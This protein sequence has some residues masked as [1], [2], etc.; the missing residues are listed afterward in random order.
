M[1]QRQAQLEITMTRR[2]M[3]VSVGLLG[4]LSLFNLIALVLSFS[5]SAGAAV[6]GMKYE[7][8]MRDPDFRRA[9]R[10]IAQDCKVNV[11]LGALKC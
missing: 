6:R 10:S 5:P 9:V 4:L 7:E 11:D 3:I 2:L 8:L 1:V